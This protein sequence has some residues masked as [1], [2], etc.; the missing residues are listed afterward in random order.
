MRCAELPAGAT[1]LHSHPAVNTLIWETLLATNVF[2]LSADIANDESTF[3][4]S[5]PNKILSIFKFNAGTVFCIN[6]LGVTLHII[7]ALGV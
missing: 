6:L 3:V 2:H 1:C 4:E 7:L 5:V